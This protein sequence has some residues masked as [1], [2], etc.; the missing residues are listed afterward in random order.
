MFKIVWIIFGFIFFVI[1]TI[2]V[3]VPLLP[4]FP[5][6]VATVFCFARSSKRL[7]EWFKSTKLYKNYVLNVVSKKS[8]T[9][10]AKAITIISFTLTMGIGFYCMRRVPVGQII[11]TFVWL[12]HVIYFAFGIKTEKAK[13]MEKVEE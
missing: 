12:G 7:E 4:T 5:F 9:L 3:F 6:Y 8:L 1:G 13:S 11:L 10:K 2:G